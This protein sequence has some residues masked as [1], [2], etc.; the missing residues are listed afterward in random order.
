MGQRTKTQTYKQRAYPQAPEKDPPGTN[1]N[2]YAGLE[3]AR[4][5]TAGVPSYD[6]QGHS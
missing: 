6:G 4:R 5:N 1:G 2:K 3:E